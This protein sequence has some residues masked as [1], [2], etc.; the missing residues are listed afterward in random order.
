[1]QRYVKI[2]RTKRLLLVDLKLYKQGVH[3]FFMFVFYYKLRTK[4]RKAFKKRKRNFRNVQA[5]ERLVY[6]SHSVLR[7]TMGKN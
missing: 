6:F 5:K 1:M 2:V 4:R 3:Q 7:K